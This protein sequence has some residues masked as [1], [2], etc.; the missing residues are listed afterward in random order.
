MPKN[1]FQIT[2][3]IS[4]FRPVIYEGTLEHIHQ[5]LSEQCRAQAGRKAKH[6]RHYR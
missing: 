3:I 1:A 2:E 5:A 4:V 6:R